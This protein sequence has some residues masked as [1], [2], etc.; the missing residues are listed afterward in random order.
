MSWLRNSSARL[1]A[2]RQQ[3]SSLFRTDTPCDPTACFD[4]FKEHW[5]QALKIIQRNQQLP[6]H[7]DV[8]GV[9][10]HLEQM[11]TLLLYDI[12]GQ[13]NLTLPVGDSNSPC[14]EYLLTE[15]ILQKLYEWGVR[16]G[17][18]A[19]AVRLEQLKLYEML[20]SQSRH[21]L[22]VHEPFLKPLLKLL[23]SCLGE[24]F[25]DDVEKRLVL[26]LNQL[27]VLLMQNI[28]L[29]DLFFI[30]ST[31]DKGV[32]KFIIFNLLV[33]FIHREGAIGMQ[34]RDALLLCMSLS[35]KNKS[36]GVYIADH[37][38]ICGLLASGISGL[39]SVLPQVLN[40]IEAEDWHR[41]T[42]DDVNDIKDL[43][44]FMNSLEFCNAVAQVAH[45]KIKEQL[46]EFLYRGFL[47][48]VMGPTL[49]Q[50]SIEEQVAA[51]AYLDLVLRSVT[52]PG[53]LMSVVKFLLEVIY[54]GRR[55]L[56]ILI[57][58]IKDTSRLSLV[59]LALF[60]TIV[61]LNCEDIMLE[62][63]FQHLKPCMHL[64]ASQIKLLN[65]F[66]PY[67]Q[68]VEKFL[69]LTPVCCIN[70]Q[71]SRRSSVEKQSPRTSISNIDQPKMIGI[72]NWNH[73]G[74]QMSDS[75]YGN[76][77]AYLCDARMKIASCKIACSV[78]SHK[79]NGRESNK[80]N[81]NVPIHEYKSVLY[82][83]QQL[84][85]HL[86]P[87]DEKEVESSD[88]FTEENTALNSLQSLGES[89][90]YE[91]LKIKPED[92][93]MNDQASSS[94]PVWQISQV[95]EENNESESETFENTKTS[96]EN[97]SVGL[98]LNVLF[99]KLETMLSNNLYINLHLTGLFS[100]LAVYSHPLLRTYLLSHKLVLQPNVR[101]LFQVIGALKQRI[102][103][104]MSQHID[105]EYEI[106][107]AKYF[108]IERE[109]KLFNTRKKTV[110]GNSAPVN[111]SLTIADPFRRDEPKR[112]SLTSSL[113]S[114]F[115]RVSQQVSEP[116]SLL[117]LSSRE[118]EE[119]RMDSIHST[120]SGQ[121]VWYKDKSEIKNYALCAVMLEEWLK[122]LAAISQE[123]TIAQLTNAAKS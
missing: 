42:P 122:E 49:L 104:Y 115:R 22:L 100:R 108:L 5:H 94:T 51:T 26:L 107:Q 106:R 71:Q 119:D 72:T 53:L 80:P 67:C 28:D 36:V 99:D 75:L 18:Y 3:R 66:D 120:G 77:H 114:M 70:S 32:S 56:H 81:V 79:Y 61:D 4:S 103:E 111:N 17:R 59:S 88:L 83:C 87:T 74:S 6:S 23:T 35:K 30:S 41:F 113:S 63:I 2:I 91:S 105:S 102:D 54:D 55:L 96:Y 43:A 69:M 40:D 93:P 89:S 92:V 12:S 109:T 112:R 98:F 121:F 60:E 20:V 21:Q 117:M 8:L 45:P 123:H 62:L 116:S 52:D 14:L 78:W 68:N 10:N 48:P 101:S 110:E 39:Y 27:C 15:N 16:T 44:A 37:S 47:I 65:D 38:N 57:N 58:R 50:T 33:P 11:V 73:Y 64:M 118:E 90:G 95:N 24:C 76:Y 25:P 9:V 86:A 13:E 84:L 7:D 82:E 1:N 85:S 34:A 97:P 29:L 46:H 19:N 31:E